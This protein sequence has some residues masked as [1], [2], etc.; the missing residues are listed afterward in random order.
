MGRSSIHFSVVAFGC[1]CHGCIIPI[2]APIAKFLHLSTTLANN[3]TP[4]SFMMEYDIHTVLDGLTLLATLGVIYCMLFTEM[5]KTY[6]KEQDIVK[7]YYVVC[8][9]GGRG[10]AVCSFR[11]EDKCLVRG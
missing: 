3:F 2:G 8:L 7:F 5:K 10:Q 6:Q 9:Q 11:G 4:S 1:C